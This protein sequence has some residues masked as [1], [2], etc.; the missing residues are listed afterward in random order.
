MRM[1]VNLTSDCL[2]ARTTGIDQ[3]SEE[4]AMAKNR[5]A[6]R[7][8][9]NK[10]VELGQKDAFTPNQV[11]RIRQLLA[12]R[13]G[14]GLRDLAL[15]SVAIDTM[16]QGPEL[17]NLT[18]KDVRRSDGKVRSIIEIARRGRK[19]PVRCTLSEKSANAL[20]KWITVSGKKRADYIFSGRS[21]S[22]SRPMTARQLSR[23]LGLR[24]S[25]L[26]LDPKKYGIE[27]LRRTKALHILNGT[28]DL[29]TVRVLLGHSKIESTARYLRIAKRSDPIA[30]SRAFDI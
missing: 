9:W 19:Q 29:E 14:R 4:R 15:F 24:I 3:S 17:L 28:G 27:S 2:D 30:I 23:L 10:G 6:K 7:R 8:A 18:V 1:M 26:G 16:L 12:R 5:P 20:R 21:D 25:E 11:K 22:S 13:G